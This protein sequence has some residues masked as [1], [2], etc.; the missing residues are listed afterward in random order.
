V[1][2]RRAGRGGSGATD[3]KRVFRAGCRE[4]QA[5]WDLLRE[6]L[7]VCPSCEEDGREL[8]VDASRLSTTIG[9]SSFGVVGVLAPPSRR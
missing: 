3:R 7:V 2:T 9:V 4:A 6:V 5:A 8:F 1:C